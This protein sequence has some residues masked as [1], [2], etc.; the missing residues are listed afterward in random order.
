[1]PVAAFP[2]L[3]LGLPIGAMIATRSLQGR[4]ALFLLMLTIIV[5]DSAQ[6]YCGRAL[7]RHLLAPAVSPKKTVEGAAGGFVFGA[8]FFATVGAWWLPSIP[9][10]L[11]GKN[12]KAT[13]ATLCY[14]ASASAK[15]IQVEVV[16]STYSNSGIGSAN[17]VVNDLTAQTLPRDPGGQIKFVGHVDKSD[18]VGELEEHLRDKRHS[19]SGKGTG[20]DPDRPALQWAFDETLTVAPP[21]ERPVPAAAAKPAATKAAPAAATSAKT[22]SAKETTPAKQGG[23]K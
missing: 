10:A 23:S 22:A 15:I 14:E 12:L 21:A 3:Y 1:M 13:A 4:E 19:V 20:Q 6:Y 9:T 16:D 18:R 7:G 2:A 11:F 5:S 8:A 17:A